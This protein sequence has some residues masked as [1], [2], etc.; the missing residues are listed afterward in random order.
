[1]TKVRIQHTSMQFSDSHLEHAHDARVLFDRAVNK[2]V[3]ACTG[4]EA[5]VLK[6]DQDL[7]DALVHQ[8]KAHDFF[9]NAHGSGEWVA[10]NRRYLTRCAR[11]FAGPFISSRGGSGAHTARG[12]A[13]VAGTAKH[14]DLGRLTFGACHYLTDRS[15]AIA[16][17]NTPI[18]RGVNT[19]ARTK[20]RG[21]R[22]VFLGADV[23][24]NDKAKDAF[25]GHPM[26]SI[27][28]ELKKWPATHEGGTVIDVIASYS[29][30]KRVHAKAYQVANDSQFKLYSDHYLLDAIYEIDELS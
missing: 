5:G 16:G 18:I 3:W 19:W 30:D 15:E 27:A 22:V 7:H 28:D 25:A 21:T 6:H 29:H 12:V 1:M 10:V 14:A 2:G 9:I 26:V 8:A 13:W 11:G 20:G 4:T 17:S 24:T 23:N